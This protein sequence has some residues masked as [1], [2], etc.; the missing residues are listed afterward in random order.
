MHFFPLSALFRCSAHLTV[1]VILLFFSALS[2]PAVLSYSAVLLILLFCS[3]HRTV[4]LCPILLFCSPYL[5]CS[6]FYSVLFRCSSSACPLRSLSHQIVSAS[7]QKCSS[8]ESL[9]PRHETAF[10]LDRVDRR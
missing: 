9:I 5:F 7:H 2:Y 4:P 1:V 6:V 8:L 3:A 10:F